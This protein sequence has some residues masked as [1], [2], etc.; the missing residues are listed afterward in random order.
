MLT[1]FG[2]FT[3]SACRAW[4]Q[5]GIVGQLLDYYGDDLRVEW[6]DFPIITADS[7]KAA[8]AGQCAR[9]QGLF[10]EYL[11]RVYSQ[12][13][14]S[15]TNAGVEK[16]RIYAKDVGLD[17]ETF[18]ACLD[19]NQHQ[20]TVEYDLD[21]ARDLKLPGTPSFLV[22]GQPV[23]GANPQLLAQ[24]IEAALAVSE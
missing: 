3:C 16:L 20:R 17:V 15:Y 9:D 7:P 23:I 5:T 22:N 18:N 10:W 1:E 6:R 12:R 21:F 8:Q 13:G 4:H 11:D 14:S 2:D 19:S 24:A